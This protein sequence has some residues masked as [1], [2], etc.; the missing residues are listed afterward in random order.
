MRKIVK[1]KTVSKLT[2]KAKSDGQ[3]ETVYPRVDLFGKDLE[4]SGFIPGASFLVVFE[5][6]K[7]TLTL[8]K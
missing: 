5:E 7:I 1:K 3:P 8:S 6:G 2:K 4:R